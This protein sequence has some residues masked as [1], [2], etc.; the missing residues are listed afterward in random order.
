MN[1]LDR[2]PA[3]VGGGRLLSGIG[4]TPLLKLNRVT[5]GVPPGVEVHVK[6]EHLNPG[7]SV[8]DR[9]ASA[10]ILDGIRSGRLT[11]ERTIIDATSGNT[12][13]AYAMI[14]AAL[15]FRV[16]LCV[17]ANLSQECSR[18]MRAYGA[19]LIETD[20]MLSSDGAQ[21]RAASL[22]REEPETYFYP[23]QYNNQANWKAHY[24]TTA[25]EIW[26]Q[27]DGRVTHFV[28]CVGTSGTLVGTA[29]RLKELDPS[30][31]A[32]MVQPDSPL[33][34]IEGTRHLSTT[35]VPGIYDTSIVD[36][37]TE[38]ATEDAHSM[39]RRLAYEEGLLVGVSSG[40][41]VHAAVRLAK[42]LPRGSVVVT[43]LCDGGHR[44]VGETWW[45]GAQA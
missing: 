19:R 17:P 23:D 7:G 40:A 20:P 10:M 14:G 44:Y 9:A 4:N 35:M 8:K 34:G 5:L 42:T 27:T 13:I 32:V 26:R 36:E 12:G 39:A 28:S 30:I 25:A 38:V 6:A 15:G 2:E 41:N 11:R 18:I 24:E 31:R 43:I 33:H 21:I 1:A 29:R 37:R 16:T 45:G 22:A 3:F